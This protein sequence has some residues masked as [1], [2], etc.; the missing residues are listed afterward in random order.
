MNEKESLLIPNSFMPACSLRCKNSNWNI[1]GRD[2]FYQKISH[3]FLIDTSL[4]S[5]IQGQ[6][7]SHS[8]LLHLLWLIDFYGLSTFSSTL[9]NETVFFIFYLS[10]FCVMTDANPRIRTYTLIAISATIRWPYH[11]TQTCFLL[12][13]QDFF[14]QLSTIYLFIFLLFHMLVNLLNFKI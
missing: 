13:S 4:C 8:I 9:I 7:K 3:F 10:F 2:S 5:T 6:M 12:I 11:I 1:W 14:F